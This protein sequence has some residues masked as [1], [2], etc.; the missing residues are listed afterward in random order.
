MELRAED[1]VGGSSGEDEDVDEDVDMSDATERSDAEEV[2]DNPSDHAEDLLVHLSEEEAEEDVSA[3][4]AAN[5]EE[6]LD[7]ASDVTPRL[8][9]SEH[10]NAEGGA[11]NHKKPDVHISDHDISASRLAAPRRCAARHGLADL[12]GVCQREAKPIRGS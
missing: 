2:A 1:D 11:D 7:D 9:A 8:G 12:C 4:P 3:S 5:A 6:Q 10:T